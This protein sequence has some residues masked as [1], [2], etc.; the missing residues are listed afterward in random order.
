MR[1]LII[2]IIIQCGNKYLENQN[3]IRDP[4]EFIDYFKDLNEIVQLTK[5][6]KDIFFMMNTPQKTGDKLNESAEIF[7]RLDALKTSVN[8]LHKTTKYFNF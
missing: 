3:G 2:E 8:T 1:E 7:K 5:F 4:E 6:E